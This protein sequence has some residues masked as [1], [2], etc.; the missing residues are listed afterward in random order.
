M[1][2]LMT[3]FFMQRLLILLRHCEDANSMVARVQCGCDFRRDT[4]P[5][6]LQKN[7]EMQSANALVTLKQVALF[8]TPEIFLQL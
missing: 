4:F 1:T 7:A 2:E 6:R 5:A 3:F 8:A